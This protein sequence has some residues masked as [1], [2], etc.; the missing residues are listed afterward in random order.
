MC[1][2]HCCFAS[3]I[4]NFEVGIVQ[5]RYVRTQYDERRRLDICAPCVTRYCVR[6]AKFDDDGFEKMPLTELVDTPRSPSNVNEETHELM[7]VSP[8]KN[9][10][11]NARIPV[12]VT[13]EE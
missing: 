11:D 1:T 12:N 10:I 4:L 5:R 3:T 13:A 2:Q 7:V 8:K 6:F 9:I